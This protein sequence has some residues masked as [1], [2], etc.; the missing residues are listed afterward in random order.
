VAQRKSVEGWV[1]FPARRR[2]RDL[3]A[4]LSEIRLSSRLMAICKTLLET[5]KKLFVSNGLQMDP[6][7][8]VTVLGKMGMGMRWENAVTQ[9]VI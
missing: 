5:A 4:S 1:R 8:E 7:M 6:V 9:L 2:G 3:A